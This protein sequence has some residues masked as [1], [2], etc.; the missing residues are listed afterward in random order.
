MKGASLI[1]RVITSR[2]SGSYSQNGKC[3]VSIF[4]ASLRELISVAMSVDNFGDPILKNID[5]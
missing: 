3:N 2:D 4:S 5:K 1:I